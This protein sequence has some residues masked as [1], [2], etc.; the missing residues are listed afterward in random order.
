MLPI[1]D[2]NPTE[3]FTI[4]TYLLIGINTAVFFHEIK[5]ALIDPREYLKFIYTY[6]MIP[7]E[8]VSGERL[9][10]L[11]TCMFV[12]QGFIHLF[13]NM[14]YLY[15]FGNN[16][17]DVLGRVRFIIFY[18]LCGLAASAFQIFVNPYSTIPNIGASG[19]ISGVLGAYLVLFPRARIHT[20]VFLGWFITATTIP[21]IYF[22]GFWFILQIFSGIGSLSY[23]YQNVGGVAYFAHAGGFLAGMILIKV[24]KKK[25]RTRRKY[26]LLY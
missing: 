19:A 10:T 21:A 18:I 22:L 20:L 9:Y 4:L 25:R 17:E 24:M 2:E 7:A 12:H 16:V 14:L 26:I 8:I 6:G 5:L 3:S 23:L 11:F 15:I 1:R 13:G